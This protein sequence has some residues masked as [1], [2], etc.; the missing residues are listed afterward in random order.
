MK[1]RIQITT[2]SIVRHQPIIQLDY[3]N[4]GGDALDKLVGGFLEDLQ[5]TSELCK[6]TYIGS[7]GDK[8]VYEI[9]PISPGALAEGFDGMNSDFLNL[10]ASV[11]KETIDTPKAP[12]LGVFSV[13]CALQRMGYAFELPE[14]AIDF[15]SASP[16]ITLTTILPKGGK[17]YV[18]ISASDAQE[19]DYMLSLSTNALIDFAIEKYSVTCY[20]NSLE[21]AEKE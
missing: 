11:I 14:N 13:K 6:I 1:S 16:S 7:N 19:R 5:H 17:V 8:K 20:S 9:M 10:V 2:S 3:Q 15:E 21:S 18:K 12:Q 4:D